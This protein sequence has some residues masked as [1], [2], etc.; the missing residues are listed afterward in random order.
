MLRGARR[1]VL[2]RRRLLAAVMAGIAVVAG[3]RAVSPPPPRTI[4]V[5]V[6]RHDLA[7]GVVLAPADLVVVPF[8]P[9]TV[10]DGLAADWAGRTLAAPLRRGEPVTD[11]RLVAPSLVEGYPGLA[12][13]PLRL[14]D[15]EAVALLRVGDR[16]DL[17]AV[18]PEHGRARALAGGVPVLALPA[19][20][21]AVTGSVVP[22]GRL[23]VLGVP[24]PLAPA[25]SEAAVREFLTYAF[26]R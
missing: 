20:A 2:A 14:P 11:V 7:A 4:G 5:A 15:P 21:G 9:E 23:V 19:P 26:S 10:P 12:A 3:I 25:I 17:F 22:A 6:A 1:A 13:V 18:D 24:R 16:I 8:A